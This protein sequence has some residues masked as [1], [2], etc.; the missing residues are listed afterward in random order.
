MSS[1]WISQNQLSWL[2]ACHP[3]RDRVSAIIWEQGECKKADMSV[4]EISGIILTRVTSVL[5]AMLVLSTQQST[6]IDSSRLSLALSGTWTQVKLVEQGVGYLMLSGLITTILALLPL[7]FRMAQQLDVSS[8]G[9]MS[10]TELGLVAAGSSDAKTYV[11]FFITTVQR[12]CLTGLLFFMMCVAER[13]Y[14]QVLFS[15]L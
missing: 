12:I 4:L 3:S 6:R 5:F 14:K 15:L 1:L 7:G 13:T 8:L 11:F 9:S 2:Q 10:L